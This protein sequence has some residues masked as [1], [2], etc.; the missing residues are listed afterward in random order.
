MSRVITVLMDLSEEDASFR[1]TCDALDHAVAAASA[2]V[3]VRVVH[4][5]AIETLVGT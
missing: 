4:T 3:M 5:D 2:D 1:Y